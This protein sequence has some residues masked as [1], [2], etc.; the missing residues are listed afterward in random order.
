MADV[1]ETVLITGGG[2]IASHLADELLETGYRVRALDGPS[3]H[4]HEDASAREHLHRV[5][6]GRGAAWVEGQSGV[7]RG[8]AATREILARGLAL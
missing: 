2:F 6:L 7:D 5:V 1:T 3:P 4:V 8:D